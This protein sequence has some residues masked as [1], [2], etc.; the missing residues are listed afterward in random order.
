MDLVNQRLESCFD[1]EVFKVFFIKIR[2]FGIG[3]FVAVKKVW[4]V[5]AYRRIT[6]FSLAL[7]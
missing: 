1:F 3:R 6:S 5:T 7:E 2:R 4:A